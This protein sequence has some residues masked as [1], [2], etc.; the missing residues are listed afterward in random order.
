MEGSGGPQCSANSWPTVI[1]ENTWNQTQSW[2]EADHSSWDRL[3]SAMAGDECVFGYVLPANKKRNNSDVITAATNSLHY[4]NHSMAGCWRLL[5]F[6]A[7]S[8]TQRISAHLCFITLTW[9]LI[10][11]SYELRV[12]EHVNRKCDPENIT[13]WFM[14]AELL[15][16][17]LSKCGISTSTGKNIWILLSDKIFADILQIN[18][19]QRGV[20]KGIPGG[21]QQKVENLS[22]T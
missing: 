22:S 12:Q 3:T 13:F 19:F 21:P 2:H 5:C 20:L 7:G 17:V 9:L 8:L 10:S 4:V 18:G 14:T 6:H 16:G 1:R 11:L 15:S